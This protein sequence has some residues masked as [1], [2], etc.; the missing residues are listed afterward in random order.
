[1]SLCKLCQEDRPLIR[2]HILPDAFNRDLRGDAS[3]PPLLI[4]NNP[5]KHPRRLPG[6]HYDE[7][8]VCLECEE[9]F[10][11]ADEYAA[12]FFLDEFRNDGE[13]FAVESTGEVLAFQYPDIDYRL[14]KMFAISLLWRASVTSIQFF[15]RVTTGPHEERLRQII[16]GDDPGAAD[17]FSTFITRWVSRP[18]HEAMA[19]TQL[20]PY[21]AKLD[22]INEVKFLFAGATMHVKVD[23]RPY[24]EPFPALIIRPGSPLIVMARELEGS[25]DILAVRRGLEAEAARQQGRRNRRT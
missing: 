16:L 11:P 6:G 19:Q 12:R 18:G 2:S 14:L 15:E 22:G 10:G 7:D 1:M 24:R 25:K 5:N 13:T 23:Q 21:R 3:T 17:E 9:R 8:L 20:S 4:S